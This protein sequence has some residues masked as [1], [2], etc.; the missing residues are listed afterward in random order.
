MIIHKGTQKIETERLILRPF[1]EEDGIDLYENVTSDEEVAK[2]MRWKAH[3]DIRGTQKI[4]EMWVAGYSNIENYNWAL[5]FKQTGYVIG[6]ISLLNV[7]NY[8]ENCEIG[9]CIGKLWWN[10]GIV[11]E[12]FSEVIKFA[13]KE[14]GFER[15]TGRH[16]VE[17]KASGRVM[18]KCGLVYEGTLRKIFKTNTGSLADCMYYSILKE[19]FVD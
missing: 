17:N 16:L 8:N 4:V 11:T 2:Y 10:K 9:Y 7:D 14:I 19:D 15:I 6:Y 3:S 13:F 1:K 18:E 12:A 5:E